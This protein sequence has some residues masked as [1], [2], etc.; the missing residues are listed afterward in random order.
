[1]KLKTR[2]SQDEETPGMLKREDE[3]EV[4]SM[5]SE[6]QRSL[7]SEQHSIEKFV[8]EEKRKDEE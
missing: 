6:W 3:S 4:T 5:K 7:L 8:L 2:K 1:M